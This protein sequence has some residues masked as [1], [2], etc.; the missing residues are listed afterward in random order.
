MNPSQLIDEVN[1]RDIQSFASGSDR[2]TKYRRIYEEFIL[3]EDSSISFSE[4]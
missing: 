1:K 3:R 4:Y 2:L